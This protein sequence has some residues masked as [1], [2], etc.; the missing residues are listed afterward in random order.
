MRVAS[1]PA[2]TLSLHLN[3]YV[4]NPWNMIKYHAYITLHST[5]V[6]VHMDA[7]VR[8]PPVNK[9]ETILVV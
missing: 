8:L 3:V 4:G 6:H 5:I 9:R 1:E 2:S 7:T